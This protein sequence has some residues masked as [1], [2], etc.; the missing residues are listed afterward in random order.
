MKPVLIGIFVAVA[1]IAAFYVGMT[2]QED[3]GPLQEAGQA[4]DQA[5]EE[6]QQTAEEAQ[7]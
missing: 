1:I 3:E 5:G 6:L 2:F 7:Q 4:L